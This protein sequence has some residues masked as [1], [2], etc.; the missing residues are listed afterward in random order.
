VLKKLLSVSGW[1]LVS[2]LTGFIRD[3]VLAAILGVGPLMDVFTVANRLPNHFRAIFAE[4]AF[5]AAFVPA[6][7]RTLEQDGANAARRFSGAIALV[8]SVALT[9]LTVGAIVFMPTIIGWLAPGFVGDPLRFDLAVALTRVTF[10]YLVFVSLVTLLSGVLNAHGRFAAAA[11][12]PVLLN[13]AIIAALV[14]AYLFP[15]AAHAA[16]WGVTA[17]GVLELVLVLA[18]ASRA[19]AMPQLAR[20]RLDKPTR[21]FFKAFLPAVIGAGGVQIAMFAD[22]ILVTLLERGAPSALYY[23]DRLY[24]LP[25]GMIGI[26]AGTVLL[27]EMSRRLAAGDTA[28]AH[29]AQNRAI[30]F[31]FVLAGPFLAIFLIAPNLVVEALFGRGAFD[32]NAAKAA[33]AVLAAYAVG[34]PAIVLIRSCIASFHARQDTTTPMIVSFVA[35]AANVALKLWLMPRMGAPGLALAT[36]FGAWINLGLLY[37]LAFQ[38]GWTSP[39]KSLARFVVSVS[40]ACATMAGTVWTALFLLPPHLAALPILRSETLLA[41]SSGAG[42]VMYSLIIWLG[43]KAF[44]LSIDRNTG[45]R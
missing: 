21:G 22:T 28:A 20:P 45:L 2:R 43:F 19:G 31:T 1:T 12:A 32:A 38:R 13:V 35:I 4:G 29:S 8:L 34:L 40:I 25:I 41:L 11:A 42:I 15:S 14:L 27:P 5:N 36:A 9:L 10:P 37:G 30:A 33:G 6:Y 7:S 39:T 16:A 17:A 18:A 44:G 23:A 24:Q 3:V 26:A